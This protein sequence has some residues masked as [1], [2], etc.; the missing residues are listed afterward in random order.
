MK[1]INKE[2]LMYILFGVLTTIVNIVTYYILTKT[3][4][5]PK[6]GIELQIATIIAWITCVT[7]A[8]FTNKK[9]VFISKEKNIK[10]EILLFYIARLFTLLIDMLL[11]YI[12]VTKL[13]LNDKVIKIIVQIIIIIANYILSKLI[14]FKKNYK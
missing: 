14:V 3:I 1:K 11:M 4:L 9:Y 2:I 8:Y 6:N 5:N 13:K 12:L 10:K 7:F